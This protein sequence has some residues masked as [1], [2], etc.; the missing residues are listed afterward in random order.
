[1]EIKFVGW[2]ANFEGPE[3]FDKA[4]P[5]PEEV[6]QSIDKV[7]QNVF[8]FR[9]KKKTADSKSEDEKPRAG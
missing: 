6:L 4:V 2:I 7:A 5:I 9:P 3:S 1:M 8:G